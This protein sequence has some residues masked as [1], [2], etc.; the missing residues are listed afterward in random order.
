VSTAVVD[1]SDI[2]GLLR[3]GYGTLPHARFTVYTVTDATGGR[4]F[5]GWLADRI[6][7]ASA[8]NASTVT[9]VALTADGMR[10]LGVPETVLSDFSLEFTTGMSAVSRSKF[11]PSFCLAGLGWSAQP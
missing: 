10:Q 8:R 4:R 9:Q 6:T 1:I 5:L 7:P 3:T 2:Q 11:L